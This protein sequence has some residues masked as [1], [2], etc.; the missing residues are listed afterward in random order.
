MV[1]MVKIDVTKKVTPK[2]ANLVTDCGLG[3]KI[4]FKK[5]RNKILINDNNIE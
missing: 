1:L 4:K 3:A 5:K 2:K